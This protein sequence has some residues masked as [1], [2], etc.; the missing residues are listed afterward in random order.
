[1]S[2]GVCCYQLQQG[3]GGFLHSQA[4]WTP[5]R[6]TPPRLFFSPTA[7]GAASPPHPHIPVASPMGLGGWARYGASPFPWALSCPS[8]TQCV[9]VCRTDQ[10]PHPRSQLVPVCPAPT[11]WHRVAAGTAP[12]PGAPSTVTTHSS[13]PLCPR[14]P[15]GKG[16]RQAPRRPLHQDKTCLTETWCLVGAIKPCPG[17]KRFLAEMSGEAGG[18]WQSHSVE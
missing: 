7:C 16:G 4:Q 5:P 10:P 1:M 11:P 8:D 17:P 18:I 2:G 13:R 12:L 9:S 6:V 14:E 15:K 3:A